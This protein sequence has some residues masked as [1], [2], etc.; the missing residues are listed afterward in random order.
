MTAILSSKFTI[1]TQEIES[2]LAVTKTLW[3]VICFNGTHCWNSIGL[4][5]DW[6]PYY[7]HF[8]GGLWRGKGDLRLCQ[9]K[10]KKKK[11]K[12]Q[13]LLVNFG[14]FAPPPQFIPFNAFV[15]KILVP[16]LPALLILMSHLNLLFQ[17]IYHIVCNKY[18]QSNKRSL[19]FC[20][21]KKHVILTKFVVFSQLKHL[22][23]SQIFL[24]NT[25][26]KLFS[27]NQKNH[28]FLTQ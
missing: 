21:Y 10:K 27:L 14:I 16:P 13:P 6:T 8:S 22:F 12:N 24:W 4:L 26:L 18:P 28:I 11:K 9:V 2:V 17:F 7:Q 3:T 20:H 19:N 1:F 5:K 15:K 23:F 25:I